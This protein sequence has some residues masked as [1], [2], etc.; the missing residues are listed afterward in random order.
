MRRLALGVALAAAFPALAQDAPP[1]GRRASRPERPEWEFA[2]TVQPATPRG[3]DTITSVVGTAD[4]G[5][6]HLEARYAYEQKDSRS[7]FVGWTFSGGGEAVKWEMTPIVGGGWGPMQAFIPGFEA[8]LAWRR[9]DAYVEAEFVRDTHARTNDYNYAW[10]EIGFHATEALRVGAAGQRTR[11][12]EVARDLQRGPFVQYAWKHVT[13]GA[14]WFNPGS[15]E[16]VF[17]G[18][19]GVSF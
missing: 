16:Q 13:L 17:V 10:S 15:S 7:A 2:L 4:A 11:A 18:S 3:G 12:Y 9:L 19:V 1:A 8:S 5:S 14:F 6:L